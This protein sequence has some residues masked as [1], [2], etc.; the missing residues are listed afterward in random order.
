MS[1]YINSKHVIKN[2]PFGHYH[3]IQKSMKCCQGMN[4][5]LLDFM[6]II[7]YVRRRRPKTEIEIISVLL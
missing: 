5:T 6:D 4:L 7:K 2:T 1:F 3:N